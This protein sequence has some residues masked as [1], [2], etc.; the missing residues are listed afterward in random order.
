VSAYSRAATVLSDALAALGSAPFSQVPKRTGVVPGTPV[1]DECCNGQLTVNL[2]RLY[3][4]DV[5][6]QDA[7]QTSQGGCCPALTVADMGLLLLRCA[8]TQDEQGRPPSMAALDS[9]AQQASADGELLY[10]SVSNS[11]SAMYQLSGGDELQTYVVLGALV[12]GPQGGCI[13]IQVD[14]FAAW[15]N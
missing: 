8:P 2:R 1:W 11:L 14:F 13:G 6:P 7:A 3:G 9:A 15:A 10:V 4:S 5:F 12:V